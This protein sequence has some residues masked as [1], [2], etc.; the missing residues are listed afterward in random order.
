MKVVILIPVYNDW[1][2][3]SKLLDEI[4]NLSVSSEFQI[5]VIIVNDASNHDRPIYE[6]DLA[7]I[8]KI[9]GKDNITYKKRRYNLLKAYESTGQKSK[10]RD[11]YKASVY[12]SFAEFSNAGF[13]GQSRMME[14]MQSEIE[15]YYDN[16]MKLGFL[17]SGNEMQ[18]FNLALKGVS[19]DAAL[20]IKN[21][22][23][24]EIES[25]QNQLREKLKPNEA[26]I[27]FLRMKN[28]KTQ[29]GN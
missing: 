18:N 28:K 24:G 23:I 29:I 26:T 2:S 7:A 6:K 25:Y 17:V 5:S 16:S 15:D 19:T 12:S 8:E 21:S 4:N 10:A 13:Q 11:F 27:D 1:Q 22:M 9:L 3:V 20:E 14:K